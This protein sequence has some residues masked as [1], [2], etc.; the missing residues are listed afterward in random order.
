MYE[1]VGYK[2]KSLAKKEEGYDLQ[3]VFMKDEKVVSYLVGDLNLFGFT[4]SFDKKYYKDNI[5]EINPNE[6][7]KFSVKKGKE[8]YETHLNYIGK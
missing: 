4:M 1:K 8:A 6:N 2:W 3:V 5:I 7:D